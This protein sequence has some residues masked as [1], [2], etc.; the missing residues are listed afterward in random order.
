MGTIL[1]FLV[2]VAL[3][4]GLASAGAALDRHVA[5]KQQSH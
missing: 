1:L 4:P 2:F 3:I 5:R